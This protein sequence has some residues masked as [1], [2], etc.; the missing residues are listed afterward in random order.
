MDDRLCHDS[1]G[2]AGR[3]RQ[4]QY[5]KS[6]RIVVVYKFLEWLT[7]EGTVTTFVTKLR[8]TCRHVNYRLHAC[9]G[10]KFRVSIP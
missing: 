3:P 2:G 7:M 6:D 10:V 4:Q 5:A 8:V 1:G 9:I